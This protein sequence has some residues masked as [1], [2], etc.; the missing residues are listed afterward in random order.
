M[1]GA[2]YLLTHEVAE[3]IGV[4]TQTLYNW[5]RQG[6]V[7]EPERNPVTRYRLWKL[8]DV[9]TIRTALRERSRL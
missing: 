2:N 7:P 4:S 3:L 8:H 5:L 9:E 6:K 1:I